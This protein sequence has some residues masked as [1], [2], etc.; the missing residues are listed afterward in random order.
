MHNFKRILLS[1]CSILLLFTIGSIAVLEPYFKT[2]M[3]Y[4]QDSQLREQLAGSIDC[5]AIGASNGLCALDTRIMD[6]ELGCNAYNLAGSLMTLKGSQFLLKKELERNPI[7]TVILDI[8]YETLTRVVKDEVGEGDTV[9]IAR[10]DS[11]SERIKYMIECV[12]LNDWDSVYAYH[13]TN[14]GIET[15]INR[16]KGCNLA[17]SAVDKSAKGFLSRDGRNVTLTKQ[18]AKEQYEKQPLNLNVKTSNV[19]QFKDLIELCQKYGTRVVL[20]TYP[21]SNAYLWETSGQDEFHRQVVKLAQQYNC[22]YYD[23]N[24]LKNRYEIINDASSFYDVEHM[25]AKGAEAFTKALCNIIKKAETENVS[26][27]FYSSYEE[28]KADSPYVEYIK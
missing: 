18:T 26:Q 24:L 14:Y 27:Y 3:H 16:L 22:E 23:G 25:S 12:P 21:R 6:Q 11:L 13:F 20:V 19:K 7:D 9:T 10:L 2:E 1:L 15:F 17:V 28:M 5:V 8:T 4:Y